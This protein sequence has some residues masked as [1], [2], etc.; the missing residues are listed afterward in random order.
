MAAAGGRHVGEDL[1]AAPGY[2]P[3]DR[4]GLS[5]HLGGRIGAMFMAVLDSTIVNVGGILIREGSRSRA[6]IRPVAEPGS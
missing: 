6:S 2:E 5:G 1:A 3:G 4:R